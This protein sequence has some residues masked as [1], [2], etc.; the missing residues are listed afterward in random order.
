VPSVG[1]KRS[2]NVQVQAAALT[3]GDRSSHNLDSSLEEQDENYDSLPAG[4]SLPCIEFHASPF[5]RIIF[6]AQMFLHDHGLPFSFLFYYISF[7][8]TFSSVNKHSDG[9]GEGR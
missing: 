8:H 4:T 3:G 9:G 5:Q 1:S 7:L 2:L 6:L